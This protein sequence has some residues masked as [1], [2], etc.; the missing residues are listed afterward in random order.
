MTGTATPALAPIEAPSLEPAIVEPPRQA[1][2][3]LAVLSALMGFGSISTDLYLPAMPQMAG[4]LAADT[5]SIEL[6]VSGFLIGFSLGQLFWGPISDRY[7]RRVPVA[8]G[9]VLFVIGSAG[10]AMSDTASTLVIW[11]I[12]QALGACAGVALSRAMV[13]DLY[14]GSRAAQMLSTLMT[15]MAIAPLLGPVIGGQILSFSG[16]R[17]IFWTLTGVGT[18]TFAALF[19]LPETLP[20]IRRN[21]QPLT[22]AFMSYGSLLGNRRLLAYGG[23][24]GFLYAGMFAY[25]AGTPF[26]YITYYHVPASLYGLLF[27]VG[28]LGIMTT[29]LVNARLV[30][31]YGGDRLFSY[32]ASAAAVAGIL[33]AATAWTGLGGLWGLV[34]PLFLFVSVTG[35]IVAN[36]IAGAL[37]GFP[38][39]AG[40]VSALVGAIHYGSGIFGSALVGTF[41]DGTPWPMAL[42]IALCGI[43]CLVCARTLPADSGR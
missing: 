32:G 13:R 18:L 10:C 1:W 2:R 36:S 41:A 37:S 3:V 12:V 27:G 30:K 20:A 35:F 34:I 8:I 15:V 40:A 17:A 28:I 21:R 38:E 26:A 42:V 31:H 23:A 33:L 19:T 29:N 22:R 25:I 5:G 6:T 39:N 43:G 7:G 24:G 14:A 11:R 9:L 16:W 4:D